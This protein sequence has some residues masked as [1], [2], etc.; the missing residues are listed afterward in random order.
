[1]SPA[2][3]CSKEDCGR[4]PSDVA[5]VRPSSQRPSR[6]SGDPPAG[7][8]PTTT[9]TTHPTNKQVHIVGAK[10]LMQVM[11]GARFARPDLLRAVCVLARKL[12]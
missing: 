8:E 2:L 1:M 5:D 6:P 9:N 12:T 4:A 7:C 11:Y 10:L 3:G